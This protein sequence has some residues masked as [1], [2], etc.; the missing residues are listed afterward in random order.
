MPVMDGFET[1]RHLK[2]LERTREI[3]I[4]FLTAVFRT[5]EFIRHGYELGA[6]DYLTKPIDN[7]LLLNRIRL[8]L[9]L[10]DRER[11]LAGALRELQEKDAVLRQINKDLE[12]RVVERTRELEN[13][14]AELLEAKGEAERYS[15]A[16]TNFLASMSHEI[17]TPM[18]VVLGLAEMLQETELTP[19]QHEFVRIMH[20]SG[21]ALLGVIN[22]ILD[23]SRIEAGRIVLIP[24]LFSIER[25]VTET[26]DMMRVAAG[27]KGLAVVLE[28]A[29]EMPATLFCDENRLRQVLLNLIGNA[30]KF[31][32]RGRIDVRLGWDPLE[33]RIL[34]LS[35]RDTGIGIAP[36][37]QAF[38]FDQFIQADAGI[39][40]Q[41]GGTGLGLAISRR[42]V[43]LMGGRIWVESRLGEGSAF[44]F[45]L[46][47]PGAPVASAPPPARPAAT[48]T[49]REER[50]LR[51]LLAEDVEENRML[52]AAYLAKSGHE[53]VM[54]SN[55][56]Q[57]VERVEEERFDVV[58]MDIQMPVED[59]Y[60][61]TRRIRQWECDSGVAPLTIIALS[62]HAMEGEEARSREAGCDLYLSKP[63][64]KK[65]L[66][67][68]IQR[69]PEWRA[70]GG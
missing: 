60:S 18:N 43:E 55:G 46:P 36:E 25:V 13:R 67:A 31:T 20:T 50:P 41:F 24:A 5:D 66:L 10:L 4:L 70:A 54:V 23:F 69:I 17:R 61:A 65:A 37:Q 33:E 3:P 45:T 51:I 26:T 42:L 22:D 63:I 29:G 38:I 27:H 40:R 32:E 21:K 35:V 59:G 2:M 9:R 28:V 11:K 7:H 15:Q 39:T 56:A 6:V 19:R 47:V 14:N 68:A 58:L 64:G 53:L 44:H 16:K 48:V 12:S 57:A 1:A 30:L 52:I 8:Y 49:V 34:L 62:A